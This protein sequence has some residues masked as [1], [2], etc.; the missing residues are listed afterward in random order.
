MRW[1]LIQNNRW[2]SERAVGISRPLPWPA[3]V[4]MLG[5]RLG[6]AR[7][8][9]PGSR[10]RE[11][12]YSRKGNPGRTGACQTGRKTLL[13]EL[14]MVSV[15]CWLTGSLEKGLGAAEVLQTLMATWAKPAS[16]TL[17]TGLCCWQP[18]GARHLG[19]ERVP[20]TGFQLPCCKASGQQW[21]PA[22]MN[23]PIPNLKLAI[24]PGTFKMESI[25]GFPEATERFLLHLSVRS[26]NCYNLFREWFCTINQHLKDVNCSVVC[27]SEKVE[28]I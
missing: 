24:I 6:W 20:R 21:S 16:W 3:V 19:W 27:N 25:E 12:L 10:G 1:I 5:L 8:S 4:E 28:M 22:R 17:R 14:E 9:R 11:V 18:G 2:R 26:I 15:S 23:T 7:G 13:W